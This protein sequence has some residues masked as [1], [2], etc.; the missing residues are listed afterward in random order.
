MAGLE[1][2]L[3][4]PPDY[5]LSLN[6][7]LN[8]PSPPKF[9]LIGLGPLSIGGAP[10]TVVSHWRRVGCS[11]VSLPEHSIAWLGGARERPRAFIQGSLVQ[12]W[13]GQDPSLGWPGP[14]VP[15]IFLQTVRQQGSWWAA[16]RRAWAPRARWE[17]RRTGGARHWC[18][19][20]W[21]V[22][23]LFHIIQTL[24]WNCWGS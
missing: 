17:W 21:V 6:T 10:W 7:L 12:G 15:A 16:N 18:L 20:N 8:H 19:R 9:F 4:H 11:S 24:H 22:V 23:I 13:R 5:F 14:I 3:F 1:S 2:P